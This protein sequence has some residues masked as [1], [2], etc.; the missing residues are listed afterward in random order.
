MVTVGNTYYISENRQILLHIHIIKTNNIKSDFCD[1]VC[2][3][4]QPKPKKAGL[5]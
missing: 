1:N 3:A 5:N 2:K 4:P